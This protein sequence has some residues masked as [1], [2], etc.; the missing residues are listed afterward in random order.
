MPRLLT[1]IDLYEGD[2]VTN[3]DAVVREIAAGLLK[4]TEGLTLNDHFFKAREHIADLKRW[5]HG[6]YHFAHPELHSPAAEAKHFCDVVEHLGRRDLRPVLDYESRGAIHRLSGHELGQW[7]R[8]WN[9]AVRKRLGSWPL[10]YSYPGYIAYIAPARP[11]GAGLWLASYG[12]NDGTDHGAAVPPP[13]RLYVAHQ[14]SSNCLVSGCAGRVDLS[15]ARRLRPLLAHGL[16][17]L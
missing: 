1:I 2:V 17:G 16:R 10:F 7:A 12:R 15:H 9:Q 11:I 8:D 6:A 4:A 14:F 5:R 3:W 13:W